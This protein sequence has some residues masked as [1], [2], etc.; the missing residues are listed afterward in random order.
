MLIR[1]LDGFTPSSAPVREGVVVPGAA[2]APEVQ[3]MLPEQP[4]TP[5]PPM[6]DLVATANRAI[7]HMTQAV[8]FEVDQQ[9]H[10]TVIKLVDTQDRRVLRQVPSEEMLEIAR[11]LE[12]MQAMLVRG[13][14]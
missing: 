9:T 12:R 6:R 11:A 14:A 13:K 2:A 4:P 7:R 5:P 10:A 3:A 1:P 8:E